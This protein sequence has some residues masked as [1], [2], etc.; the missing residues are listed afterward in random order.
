[1]MTTMMMMTMMTMMMLMLWG[2]IAVLLACD[3]GIQKK[4]DGGGDMRKLE[5]LLGSVC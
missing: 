5:P 3:T 1:M 4:A 2:V